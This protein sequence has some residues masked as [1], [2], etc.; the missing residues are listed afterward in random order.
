MQSFCDLRCKPNRFANVL[1]GLHEEAMGAFCKG[2]MTHFEVP[3]Y[4][5]FVRSAEEFPMTVTGKIQK[6]RM[7]EIAI[8]ELGLEAA[9]RIKTA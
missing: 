8:E 3:R 2:K 4:R 9:A 5:K 1:R 7:R 6:F